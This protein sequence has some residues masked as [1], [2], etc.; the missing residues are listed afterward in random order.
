MEG[1]YNKKGRPKSNYEAI[2]KIRTHND[3]FFFGVA[4]AVNTYKPPT[5]QFHV[6]SRMPRATI[7]E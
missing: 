6:I 1:I 7:P 4:S 2:N 5:I 3:F